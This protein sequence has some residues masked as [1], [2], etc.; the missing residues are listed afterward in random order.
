[1]RTGP[2]CQALKRLKPAKD[3]RRLLDLDDLDSIVAIVVVVFV[4][5]ILVFHFYSYVISF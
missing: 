1:M 2:D 3:G 5:L 4:Y